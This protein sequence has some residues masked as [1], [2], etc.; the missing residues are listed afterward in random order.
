[1]KT[2]K[3]ELKPEH[4][5]L[6]R[7]LN[8]DWSDECYFGAPSVNDK[9]PYQDSD[10]LMSIAEIIGLQVSR[11]KNDEKYLTEKQKGYC[12]RLHRE[13]QVAISVMLSQGEFEC[14]VYDT[15]EFANID[16]IKTE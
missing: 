3:F 16:W 9:R 1:M 8:I 5:M 2:K 11:D 14:G 6:A 4:I 12:K 13:M 15:R 7:R 10:I